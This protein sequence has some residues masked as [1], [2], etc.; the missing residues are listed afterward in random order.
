MSAIAKIN[1]RNRQKRSI[2]LVEYFQVNRKAAEQLFVLKPQLENLLLATNSIS[3]NFLSA[4]L[5]NSKPMRLELS[6]GRK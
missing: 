3:L 1:D 4:R 6:L 5:L 2:Y